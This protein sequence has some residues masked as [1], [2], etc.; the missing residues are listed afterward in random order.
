MSCTLKHHQR[1]QLCFCEQAIGMQACT[2]SPY[3][4]HPNAGRRRQLLRDSNSE[5]SVRMANEAGTRKLLA[6][7]KAPGWGPFNTRLEILLALRITSQIFEAAVALLHQLIIVRSSCL[8]KPCLT[9]V[10]HETGH[11][12]NAVA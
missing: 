8:L 9:F 6:G 1:Q 2:K 12:G 5:S 11:V 3:P 4:G 10:C 7:K